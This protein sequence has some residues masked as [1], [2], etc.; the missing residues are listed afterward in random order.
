MFFLQW[1]NFV[2]LFL[3]LALLGSGCSSKPSR[4]PKVQKT[5]V[6]VTDGTTPIEGV[7]V[8]LTTESQSNAW[9]ISAI[10]DAAGAAA[11]FTAQNGYSA[12]GAP[13]GQYKVIVRKDPDLPSQ[14]ANEEVE[15]MSLEEQAKYHAK[16][17]REK[18]TIK[19]VIPDSL[20]SVRSTPLT[21]EVGNGSSELTIDISQYK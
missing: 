6:R 2:L 19:S 18:A 8:I 15:K 21:F 17:D 9:G 14:L 1:K 10:T 12:E 5:S 7:N 11:F 20:G 4:F 16:I 3:M 13:A